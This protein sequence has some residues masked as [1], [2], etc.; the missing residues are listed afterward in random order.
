MA[1]TEWKITPANIVPLRDGSRSLQMEIW[2]R[3]FS[4][5]LAYRFSGTGILE[6]ARIINGRRQDH[7]GFENR[8]GIPSKQYYRSQ[9][10]HFKFMLTE[11][12]NNRKVD[13]KV[14]NQTFVVGLRK[15]GENGGIWAGSGDRK[16]LQ[17][18][19]RS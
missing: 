3:N 4:D 17:Y 10:Q 16:R 15:T 6:A 1:P 2:L 5:N 12:R 14:S 7:K 9:N 8:I 13:G 11:L 19:I 18:M